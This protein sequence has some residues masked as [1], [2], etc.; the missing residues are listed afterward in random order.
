M[1]LRLA[2]DHRGLGLGELLVDH[3]LEEGNPSS[4]PFEGPGV[5]GDICVDAG[6]RSGV[7]RRIRHHKSC[8][9]DGRVLQ[10]VLLGGGNPRQF[11]GFN[12]LGDVAVSGSQKGCVHVEPPC[13]RVNPTGGVSP[14]G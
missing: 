10:S 9:K 1:W 11:L 12:G 4:E 7:A 5:C 2:S 6:Q 14:G 3:R 8:L 13:T